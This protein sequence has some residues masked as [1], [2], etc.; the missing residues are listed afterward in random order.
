MEGVGGWRGI[1]K[2]VIFNSRGLMKY[3]GYG[4]M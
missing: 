2:G 3:Y 4:I 1:V